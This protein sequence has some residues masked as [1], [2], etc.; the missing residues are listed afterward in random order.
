MPRSL[1]GVHE[2]VEE[3]EGTREKEEKA[4]NASANADAEST[5]SRRTTTVAARGTRLKAS[6]VKP[7]SLPTFFAASKES[8]CRPAQGQH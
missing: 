8:R 4:T 1:T 7:L 2:R 5:D 6:G 3:A